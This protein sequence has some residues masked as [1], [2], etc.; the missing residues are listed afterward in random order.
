[1]KISDRYSAEIN[2]IENDIDTLKAGQL[3]EIQDAKGYPKASTVGIRLEKKFK[4]LIRKIENDEPGI[5][6]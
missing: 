5:L 2:E 4:E 1:M 3:Y 6:R